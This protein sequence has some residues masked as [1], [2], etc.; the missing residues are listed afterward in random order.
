MTRTCCPSSRSAIAASWARRTSGQVVSISRLPAASSRARSRS[1]TPCAVIRTSGVSGIAVRDRLVRPIRNPRASR[2]RED[3]LVVDELAVDRHRA[4][5]ATRADRLQG[6]A[7]PEAH[8]QH[9][10]PD[11]S[12]G[13]SLLRKELDDFVNSARQRVGSKKRRGGR[14][15]AQAGDQP[16][17]GLPT[18]GRRPWRRRGR[19]RRRFRGR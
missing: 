14:R 10:R 1:L 6:V 8:P 7:D 19:R 2:S 18:G 12:H 11:H 13:D 9:L 4:G 17:A 5:S 16:S 3:D 15:A